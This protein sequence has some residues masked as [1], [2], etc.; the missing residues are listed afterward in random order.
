MRTD[1]A[2]NIFDIARNQPAYRKQYVVNLDKLTSEDNYGCDLTCLQGFHEKVLEVIPTSS[3]RRKFMLSIVYSPA[4]SD[5]IQLP[6]HD[7]AKAYSDCPDCALLIIPAQSNTTLFVYDKSHDS[8]ANKY[9]PRR[10][11]LECGYPLMFHALLLHCGDK[12]MCENIRFHYYILPEEVPFVDATYF[13]DLA[14]AQKMESVSISN[15]G[16][17]R[18]AAEAKENKRRAKEAHLS[19][20]RLANIV[21]AKRPKIV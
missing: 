6:H 11:Q 13:P 21:R 12:Y 17:K 2:V 8:N 15:E 1:S 5:V 20:L 4:N 10:L 7:L 16:R 3:R 19:N 18:A 9:T 14:T